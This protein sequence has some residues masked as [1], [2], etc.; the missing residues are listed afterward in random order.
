MQIYK[1]RKVIMTRKYSDRSAMRYDAHGR[2]VKKNNSNSGI[3]RF[4]L[5]FLLPYVL[6]N[7]LILLFVIQTPSI[8]ADEPDTK[9]YLNADVSF[10]VSSILPL[11]SVTAT[12][13]GQDVDLVKDGSTYKCTVSTNGNLNVTAVSINNMTK[14]SHIQVNLLDET[15]P[16]IDEN[17]VVLGAGYLEFVV[18][19]TQSGI[20]WDSIYGV[21]SLG[22]N[23]KPTDINQA[24]GKITFSMAADAITVYVKDNAN[25]EATANFS[26]TNSE[27]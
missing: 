27:A 15:N 21:D 2:L 26:V 20:N 17:S 22:N 11:K 3:L 1:Q 4:L 16:V 10:K 7:G 6:I 23:V 19:D 14:S 12:I 25:N 8:E 9:D 5:G 13:E 24:T 18:S